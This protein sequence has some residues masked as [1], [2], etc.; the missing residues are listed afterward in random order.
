[1]GRFKTA[2]YWLKN[3]LAYVLIR[4]HKK[5]PLGFL[6]EICFDENKIHVKDKVTLKHKIKV[7]SLRNGTKFSTIHMGSS[8]YFLEQEILVFSKVKDNWAEKLLK[9]GTLEI[10]RNFDLSG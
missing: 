7:H 4:K 9:E 8:R 1:M 10:E 3:L 5:A 2:A 6:R